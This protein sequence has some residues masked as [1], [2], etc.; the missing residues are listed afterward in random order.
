MYN[1]AIVKC[2][3]DGKFSA[4]G[5]AYCSTTCPAGTVRDDSHEPQF[6][7]NWDRTDSELRA[8]CCDY[9]SCDTIGADSDV[10]GQRPDCRFKDGSCTN[11]NCFSVMTG[12]SLTCDVG[13]MRDVHDWHMPWG[14]DWDS[15]SDDETH[16]G[17]TDGG[18]RAEDRR[19]AA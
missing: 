19:A 18:S 10:C 3:N 8:Q 6:Y 16:G 12:K 7:G 14:S 1:S 4:E 13:T 2:V 11:Q 5:A 17:D 15:R 9:S